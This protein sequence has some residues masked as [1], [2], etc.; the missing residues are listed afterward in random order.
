VLKDR[1]ILLGVTGSIAAYKAPDLVR[2]L[3][4]CGASVKVVMTAAACRFITP[5]TFEAV[6]GNPCL[7]ELFGDPFSHISL[8]GDADLFI[9]APA[10][11]NTINKINCGIADNLLTNLW[12]TY[13][14]PSVIAPAMNSR[15]YGHLTVKRSIAALKKS[16]VCLAGPGSGP[17][18]CGEEGEGRMADISVIVEAARRSLS[19]QDLK[20]KRVLIT[21]GPTR[22]AIDPVRFISNRSSGKMGYAVAGEALRRG[23]EV[24][25]VTGPSNLTAPDGVRVISVETALSME[26]AVLSH[27]KWANVLIMTAAVAD[28][29]PKKQYKEKLKKGSINSLELKKTPDIL[30][31][32]ASMKGRRIFIGFAA[33][34][35]MDRESAIGKLRRKNLDYIV[36]NDI[37]ATGAGF[38][39]DTNI[40]TIFGRKGEEE[41]YPLMPKTDVANIILDRIA[42]H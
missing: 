20:G 31:R 11:A 28:F 24:I 23:A 18:A 12:L 13:R 15:M 33:E 21:A 39:T 10:T 42:N 30:S 5:Y 27:L 35:G 37:S 1:N 25:L 7:T 36:L 19:A 40:V 14:G 17:L 4:E 8:S 29:S 41:S 3:K 34:S 16:G 38:D 26:K 22:E 32:A 9:I 2:R 6:S